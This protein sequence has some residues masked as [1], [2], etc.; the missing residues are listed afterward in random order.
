[1]NCI[2]TRKL[3]SA[4]YDGELDS[5]EREI[6]NTHLS[7]CVSCQE[8]FKRMKRIGVGIKQSLPQSTPKDLDSHILFMHRQLPKEKQQQVKAVGWFG[9]PGFV[10]GIGLIIFGLT[11]V[12][13]F[14]LGVIYSE[15]TSPAI[16]HNN[17]SNQ[18]LDDKSMLVAEKPK[19]ESKTLKERI[20][21]VPII[22]TK[23]VTRVVYRKADPRYKRSNR[24]TQIN[25]NSFTKNI[26][27]SQR[28][29]LVSEIKPK[30]LKKGKSDD[31]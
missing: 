2:E 13:A 14:Q 18:Q 19:I 22:K 16:I 17:A 29:E 21:E 31:E 3:L 12:S 10:F 27:T 6:T 24:V 5:S 4:L 1:M 15:N 26:R 23:Y 30:I 28:F 20:A 9:I 11:A 7:D 8:M 25:D